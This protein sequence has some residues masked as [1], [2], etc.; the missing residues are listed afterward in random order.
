[1]TMGYPYD[2]EWKALVMLLEEK[3]LTTEEEFRSLVER[4]RKAKVEEE[5]E[6]MSERMSSHP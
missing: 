3:G 4:V 1:M 6:W 2:I 5:R